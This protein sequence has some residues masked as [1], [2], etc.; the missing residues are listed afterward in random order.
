MYL[1]RSSV[2][3]ELIRKRISIS[4]NN[5]IFNIKSNEERPKHGC[6]CDQRTKWHGCDCCS[7]SSSLSRG[8]WFSWRWNISHKISNATHS[9]V[10]LTYMYILNRTIRYSDTHSLWWSKICDCM[11]D[12]CERFFLLKNTNIDANHNINFGFF[13]LN[14]PTSS[15]ILPFSDI[16]IGFE[17]FE[18]C[19]NVVKWLMPISSNDDFLRPDTPTL[20]KPWRNELDRRSNIS[21]SICIAPEWGIKIKNKLEYCPMYLYSIY[22]RRNEIIYP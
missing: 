22:G 1:C 10:V 11:N 3:G 6:L 8:M 17:W 15:P 4:E 14:W 9:L 16:L 12:S 13:R 7:S 5:L 20:G 2:Q 19:I 18:A 21:L